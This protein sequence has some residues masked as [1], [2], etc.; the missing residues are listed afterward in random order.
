VA[1]SILLALVFKSD[2]RPDLVRIIVHQILRVVALLWVSL[3]LAILHNFLAALAA[4]LE[5]AYAETE[6]LITLTDVT[7]SFAKGTSASG[8]NERMATMLSAGM[9]SRVR[10]KQERLLKAKQFL[11]PGASVIGYLSMLIFLAAYT[12]VI[13]YLFKL[14]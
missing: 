14:W 12:L 6:F 5:S 8:M 2:V 11:Y 7:V 9:R 3:V 4:Q 1:A 10:P 13:V